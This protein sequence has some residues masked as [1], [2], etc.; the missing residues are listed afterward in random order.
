MISLLKK[1]SWWDAA[2]SSSFCSNRMKPERITRFGVVHEPSVV[3]VGGEFLWIL[4]LK[5]MAGT[6]DVKWIAPSLV[7]FMQLLGRFDVHILSNEPIEAN[8]FTINKQGL[9]LLQTRMTRPELMEILMR[10]KMDRRRTC[11]NRL[12]KPQLRECGFIQRGD[13]NTPSALPYLGRIM[14]TGSKRERVPQTPDPNS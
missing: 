6:Q 10:N 13:T 11:W 7:V 14:A 1:C 5:S 3:G 8:Q 2:P 12:P 4:L 9:C